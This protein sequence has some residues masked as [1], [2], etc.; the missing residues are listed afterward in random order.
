MI[1]LSYH[2]LS[3]QKKWFQTKHERSKNSFS[4]VQ[5]YQRL[6]CCVVNTELQEHFF[7][8]MKKYMIQIK[9]KNRFQIGSFK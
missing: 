4:S 7:K 5:F 9:S 3:Y 1:L 8:E 6:F 2:I